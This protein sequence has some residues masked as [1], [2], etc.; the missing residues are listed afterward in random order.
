MT[1]SHK[2]SYEM[3]SKI[4]IVINIWRFMNVEDELKYQL[5]ISHFLKLTLLFRLRHYVSKNPRQQN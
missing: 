1:E 5:R 3:K 2:A 4:P